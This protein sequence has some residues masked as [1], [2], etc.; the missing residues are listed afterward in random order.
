M[1]A[2]SPAS[3]AA[4]VGAIGAA[5]DAD[6]GVAVDAAPGLGNSTPAEQLLVHASHLMDKKA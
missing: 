3:T 1:R 4:D 6:A 2:I 5:T